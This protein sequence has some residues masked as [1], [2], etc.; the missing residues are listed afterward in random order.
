LL[1]WCDATCSTAHVTDLTTRRDIAIPLPAMSQTFAASQ[2]SPDGRWFAISTPGTIYLSDARSGKTVPA[3]TN[4]GLGQYPRLAWSGDSTALFMNS[5]GEHITVGRYDIATKD[6]ELV[7]LPTATNAAGVLAVRN[8]EA[9]GLLRGAPDERYACKVAPSDVERR[10]Q[11]LQSR[12]AVLQR[13]LDAVRADSADAARFGTQIARL[14]L[15]V[16]DI[17]SQ[18]PVNR[19]CTLGPHG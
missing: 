10:V 11:A 2:L 14:R 13:K 15:E 18:T 9:R 19:T 3:F 16:A 8:E 5:G 1:A 7:T 12:I 4:S 17:Q 6:S